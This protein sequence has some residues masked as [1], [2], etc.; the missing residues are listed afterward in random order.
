MAHR[1]AGAAVPAS[2]GHEPAEILDVADQDAEIAYLVVACLELDPGTLVADEVDPV[3]GRREARAEM[4]DR[5][6]KHR[7]HQIM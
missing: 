6:V 3:G 2:I 1:I 5:R 4:R 7:S